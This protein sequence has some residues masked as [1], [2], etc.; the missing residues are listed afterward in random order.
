MSPYPLYL[1][2][3]RYHDRLT[4]KWRMARYKAELDVIRERH[5]EDFEIVGEPMVIHGPAG[6]AF[7]PF[8]DRRG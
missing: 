3:F 2:P 6:P 5:G 7:N 8:G 1:Y 4:G